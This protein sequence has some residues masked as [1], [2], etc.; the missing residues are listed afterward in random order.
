MQGKTVPQKAKM[1]L[2]STPNVLFPVFF[3][4]PQRPV[5]YRFISLLVIIPAPWVGVE[6][7][8]QR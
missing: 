8:V 7:I 5:F 3:V 2:F 4:S 1:A 6:L